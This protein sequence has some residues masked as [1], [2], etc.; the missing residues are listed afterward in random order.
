MPLERNRPSVAKILARRKGAAVEG[1][2][3][4]LLVLARQHQRA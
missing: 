2:R 4:Q 3:E 1:D